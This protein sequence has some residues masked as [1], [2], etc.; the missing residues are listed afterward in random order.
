M[1][2]SNPA[3]T[4]QAFSELRAAAANCPARPVVSPV[5]E[6]TT[7]TRFNPAP[8]ASWPQV[9]GVDRLAFDFVTTDDSGQ[10][11]HSV[12]VY[13]RRGRVLM[14]VYFPRPDGPQPAVGGQ[15]SIAGIVRLFATRV[16]QVPAAVAD[17][18]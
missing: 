8:D 5:G 15:T 1:L 6:P 2:Y 11:Q 3:A 18:G 12:A 7:T 13:L 17:S 10:S 4:V 16:A 14:G 9:Q